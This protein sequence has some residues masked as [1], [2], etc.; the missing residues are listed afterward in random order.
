MLSDQ[1]AN[2]LSDQL[3]NTLSDQLANTLSDQNLQLANMNRTNIGELGIFKQTWFK[4]RPLD[5][6]S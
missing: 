5:C 1:L 6:H 3:A 4:P 2:T